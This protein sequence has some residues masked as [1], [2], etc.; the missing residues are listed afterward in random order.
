MYSR[1]RCGL[2]DEAREVVVALLERKDFDFEEVFIDGNEELE[3]A[4]GLRVP[5]VLLD[6]A[7]E[8]ETR[9][10]SD[11]LREAL[12]GAANRGD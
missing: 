8:F 7:E 9:V 1:K 6:G 11:L 12:G 4:Y 3:M 10:E 2:C 5:V